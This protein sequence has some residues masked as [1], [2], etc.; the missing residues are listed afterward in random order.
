VNK[1]KPGSPTI[2]GKSGAIRIIPYDTIIVEESR[3]D[4]GQIT[5][6]LKKQVIEILRR[7]Q[8]IE[9]EIDTGLVII[10][11]F[12]RDNFTITSTEINRIKNNTKIAE[13]LHTQRK[14]KRPRNG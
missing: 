5:N 11:K 12:D 2:F 14:K 1:S 8:R 4:Q 7:K 9:V 13:E 6:L 3:I 10:G